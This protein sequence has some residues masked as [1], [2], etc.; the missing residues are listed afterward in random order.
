[1]NFKRG[2]PKEKKMIRWGTPKG[3]KMELEQPSVSMPSKSK[4]K[5]K[6]N[7]G[8]H[9]WGP[10]QNHRYSFAPD[11]LTGR[12]DRFCLKCNKTD[13]WFAPWRKELNWD[14]DPKARPPGYEKQESTW[15]EEIKKSFNDNLPLSVNGR[16]T[17]S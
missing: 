13:V 16:P 15:V 3:I 11:K 1:M 8:D 7:K 9:I 10:W 17:L 14:T 2:Y 5:C 4:F 6:R 12:W